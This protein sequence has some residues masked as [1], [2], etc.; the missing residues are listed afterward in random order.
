MN[1]LPI[2]LKADF[3]LATVSCIKKSANF[4]ER[5]MVVGKY[6]VYIIKS[7]RVTSMWD[8]TWGVFFWKEMV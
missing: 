3:I 7:Y 1:R 6:E 5:S 2:R 4:S 8:V